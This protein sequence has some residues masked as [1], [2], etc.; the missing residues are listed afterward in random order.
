MIV[1]VEE[2]DSVKDRNP[3]VAFTKNKSQLKN[4]Q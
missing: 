1:D 2:N 4:P 3:S